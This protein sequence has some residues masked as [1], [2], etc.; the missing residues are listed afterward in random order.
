[1]SL[2]LTLMKVCPATFVN[3]LW[4]AAHVALL[5]ALRP[6]PKTIVRALST[7][8]PVLAVLNLGHSLEWGL[9]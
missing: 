4:R 6:N 7:R 8:P 1:M 3:V 9:K 2:S 5:L